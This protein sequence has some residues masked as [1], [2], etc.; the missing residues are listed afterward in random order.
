M[1][2]NVSIYEEDERRRKMGQA[3]SSGVTDAHLALFQGSSHPINP[4]RQHC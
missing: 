1:T 2:E 3:L 4:F